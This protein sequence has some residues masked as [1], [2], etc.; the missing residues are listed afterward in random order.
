MLCAV[1]RSGAHFHGE[2][3]AR[4]MTLLKTFNSNASRREIRDMHPIQFGLDLE[5]FLHDFVLF[6]LIPS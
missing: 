4:V 5:Q 3:F 1:L 6:V 2:L